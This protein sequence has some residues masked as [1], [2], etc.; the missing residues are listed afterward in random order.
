MARARNIK[1][2]IMDNEDLAE[3][4]PMVRLLFIYLWMLA[5]REGRLEDRPKRIAAQ[6]LAYDRSANVNE[7][8]SCLEK[9]GFISRYVSEGIACIQILGFAKHQNPHIR[10]AASTIP[11]MPSL[12]EDQHQPRKV[13]EWERYDT[14]IAEKGARHHTDYR[15]TNLGTDEHLPRSP[16]SLIPDSLIPDSLI[17]DSLIP[18]STE[19]QKT[20]RATRFDAQ[21]HLVEIGI[22]QD[23]AS[24][25]IKLRKTK[26]A[27]AT[28]TAINGISEEAKK[29]GISLEDALKE[30]CSRGWAGFKADWINN[31]GPPNLHRLKPTIEDRNKAVAA[32]WKPPEMRNIA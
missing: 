19:K 28:K 32:Q 3:L 5:D 4:D 16:D 14:S 25:W 22:P 11:A 1:P 20:V 6:A 8:L 31:T 2:S 29:A 24:D 21:A 23:L 15:S 26:K 17:P 30:C 9:S 10:E 27:E 18:D 12:G 7:M 13:Q